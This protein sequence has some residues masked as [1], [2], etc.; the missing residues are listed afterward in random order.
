MARDLADAVAGSLTALAAGDCLGL[1]V[2]GWQPGDIERT[3]GRLVSFYR[4]APSWS[5]DTQQALILIEGLAREGR[6]T[7][8]WFGEALVA[9]RDAVSG[10]RFGLHRGTG[11]GF[12]HAVDAYARTRDWRTSADPGR[13]GNGAAMRI[14]PFAVALQRDPGADLVRAVVDAT[15]VT[16]CDC[17]SIAAALAVGRAAQAMSEAPTLP[18]DPADFLDTVALA[19]AEDA[20]RLPDLLPGILVGIE[21]VHDC[22]ELLARLAAGA[23]GGGRDGQL[24]IIQANVIDALGP[25]R[26]ATDG[27]ALGSPIAAIV[28]AAFAP[29]VD[30][31]LVTAVNLGGDADSTGAMVGGILGAAAGV[32]GLPERLRAFPGYEEL[33]AWGSAAADSKDLG[34][35]PDLLDLERRLSGIASSLHDG[36]DNLHHSR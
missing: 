18:V 30:D 5:D 6:V 15:V 20:E 32:D 17:R 21:H 12:R 33:I 4:G 28:V 16:S 2:E 31:G 9:R 7:P 19:S 11:R 29:A 1:P 8:G 14:A 22:A 25:G 26:L 36:P 10:R 24:D 23:S 13:V 34:A 3:H 27:W 35:L